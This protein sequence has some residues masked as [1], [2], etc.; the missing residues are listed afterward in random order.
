VSALAAII[1]GTEVAR[2]CPDGRW[3]YSVVTCSGDVHP[4]SAC[5]AC[6]GHDTAAEAYSHEFAH[7]VATA[8]FMARIDP[9]RCRV[10]GCPHTTSRAALAGSHLYPLCAGHHDRPHLALL[11]R[12]TPG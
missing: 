3:R 10:P 7:R 8:R 11:I 2:A 4:V 9:T 6:A 1:P 12:V 5:H